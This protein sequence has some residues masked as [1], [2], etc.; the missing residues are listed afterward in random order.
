[1]IVFTEYRG[2]PSKIQSIHAPLH[3]IRIA[4]IIYDAVW[5]EYVSLRFEN[6][7]LYSEWWAHNLNASVVYGASDEVIG[8]AKRLKAHRGV[9][10]LKAS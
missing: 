9:N 8:S 3:D 7:H 2:K 1:M 5:L 6:L 10:L 4:M